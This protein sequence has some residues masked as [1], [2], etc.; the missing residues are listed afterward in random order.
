M[1]PECPSPPLRM[2]LPHTDVK[3]TGFS[4]RTRRIGLRTALHFTANCSCRPKNMLAGAAKYRPL[5]AAFRIRERGE[6]QILT[7]TELAM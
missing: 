3:V 4:V 2:L 1:V 7:T 5:F 6:R